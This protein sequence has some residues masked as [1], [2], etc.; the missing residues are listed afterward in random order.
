MSEPPPTFVTVWQW[1]I[2]IV[3]VIVCVWVLALSGNELLLLDRPPA[4]IDVQ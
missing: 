4:N 1:I 2:M 3:V